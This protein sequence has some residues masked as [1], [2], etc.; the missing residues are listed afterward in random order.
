MPSKTV[1]KTKEAEIVA[2]TT[3]FYVPQYD[4]AVE[5]ASAEEAVEIA[6]KR[7]K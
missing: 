2:P 6:K 4:I 1:K 7:S 5:A 3:A